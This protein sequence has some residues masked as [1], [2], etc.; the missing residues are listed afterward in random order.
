MTRL[1]T[2]LERTSNITGRLICWLLL[3]MV[4]FSCT[5][6]LLRYGFNISA[7]SLQD[8]LLYSHAAV[9]LLG[10]AYTLQQDEHVRVDIFYS[11]FNTRQKAWVNAVGTLVFLLPFTLFLLLCGWYYFAAALAIRE[12]S[13]NPSGLGLVYLFKGLIP[14]AMLLLLLQAI[15]LLLQS[16]S[17]LV[18]ERTPE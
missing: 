9:F 4:V 12:G 11:R 17:T 16:A 2:I 10:A 7:G 15:S 18:L 14:L 1:I 8:L 6:V 3:L 13:M 5:V